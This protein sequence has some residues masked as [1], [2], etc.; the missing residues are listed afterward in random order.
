MAKSN[1]LLYSFIL[2]IQP[3]CSKVQFSRGK[4]ANLFRF[5][6][7]K[8]YP[9]LESDLDSARICLSFFLI[10]F[11]KIHPAFGLQGYLKAIRELHTDRKRLHHAPLFPLY[12]GV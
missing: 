2:I 12:L 10:L 11:L 1:V 4:I 6:T 9:T 8:A 5:A 7:G 3:K